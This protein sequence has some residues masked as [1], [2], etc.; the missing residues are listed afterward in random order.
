MWL[1]CKIETGRSPDYNIF[2]QYWSDPKH[3]LWVI[4]H[5]ECIIG[6]AG[7][8][9]HGLNEKGEV[10]HMAIKR[11]YKRNGLAQILLYKLI[12]YCEK[13]E[14]EEIILFTSVL[15]LPAERLYEKIGFKKWKMSKHIFIR[16]CIEVQ[17]SHFSLKL[18][19][20]NT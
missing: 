12:E 17:T 9:E 14:Y 2:C 7:L 11:R 19:R 3:P 5:N 1:C 16:S 6:T 20:T 18:P 13:Y 8:A 4:S 10:T 15:Q